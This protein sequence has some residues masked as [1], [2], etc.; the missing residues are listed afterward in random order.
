MQRGHGEVVGD[1]PKVPAL[2]FRPNCSAR[3]LLSAS[4]L[5]SRGLCNCLPVQARASAAQQYEQKYAFGLIGAT[6]LQV[7]SNARDRL[8]PSTSPSLAAEF[9]KAS[10]HDALYAAA[11]C[12]SI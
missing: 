8:D 10:V 11:C 4:C 12:C 3:K 6:L 5:L 7:P 1:S 2:Q 9:E